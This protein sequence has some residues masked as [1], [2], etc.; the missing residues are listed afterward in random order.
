[1]I[2]LKHTINGWE[3]LFLFFSFQAFLAALILFFKKSNLRRANIIWGVFLLLFS[4]N[5]FYNVLYWSEFST[6]LYRRLAFIYLIPLS[7]YGGLF[8]LYVRT[9]VTNNKIG[10]LDSLHLIPFLIVCLLY[11]PFYLL[12]LESRDLILETGGFQELI[13]V[14]EKYVVWGL[15]LILMIYAVISYFK[16]KRDYKGDGEMMLWLKLIT[17][18]FAGFGL[19]WIVYLILFKL[20]YLNTDH[21]YIIT[22]VMVFFVGLTTYFGFV[23]PQVF[24][25]KSLIRFLPILKYRKSGLTNTLSVELRN[26]LLLIMETKAPYLDSNLRLTDLAEML[27]VNRHHASQIINESFKMSFFEFV[28]NYR[29]EEAERLI[30]NN[31]NLKLTDIAYQAGFNNRITFY[32]AFKAKNGVAPSEYKR[33]FVST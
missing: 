14:P 2:L 4:Y 20:A 30:I 9:L 15:A 13:S 6:Y 3:Q 5:I 24:S 1:M 19:T 21:D 23:Q 18:L 7:L 11:S 25:G 29:V 22:L 32:K 8:Y 10:L 12:S 16:F 33:N 28:N 26:E 31:E 17:W 27:N